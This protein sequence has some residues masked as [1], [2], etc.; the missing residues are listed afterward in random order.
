M[1]YLSQ[2][3]A[4]LSFITSQPFSGRVSYQSAVVMGRPFLNLDFVV[5][6]FNFLTKFC[7]W[8]DGTQKPARQQA[9]DVGS[10]VT[11]N[12]LTTRMATLILTLIAFYFLS[13]FAL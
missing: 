1:I 3:I 7:S 5:F 11:S 2:P 13:I 12:S 4:G 10:Y 8:A 9:V 6:K